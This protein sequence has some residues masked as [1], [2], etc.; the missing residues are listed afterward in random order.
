MLNRR[1]LLLGS[2]AATGTGLRSAAAQGSAETVRTAFIG[3]GNR[4]TYLLKGTIAHPGVKVMA[5]CDIK[6]D[7]L[8]RAATI[9]ANDK[10]TTYTDWRRLIERKDVDAVYIATPCDLHVEMAL[11]ALQAGKHIYCEKPIGV[12][13]ESVNRLWRAGK[14]AKTVFQ[15]GLG[16]RSSP[17]NRL[18]I[19]KIHDGIAGKLVMIRAWR[20]AGNDL[21]HNGSSND[22]F[23]N[24]KRSGD[25][26]VEMAVHNVDVCNWVAN[27]RP[28]SAGGY[29]GALVW[30]NE[31]PGRTNMDGYT[32][33]YDYANGVKL[34]FTQVFFHP[35]QM[36][37]GGSACLAY[38][39]KGGVDLNSATYYPREPKGPPVKL[40]EEDAGRRR[41]QG[42]PDGH[43][44]NFLNAI[45]TG[46]K[47]NAD[48]R[49]G[50]TATLTCILGREAIYKKRTMTW[51]DLGVDL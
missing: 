49:V 25:V 46:E 24:A 27:S 28:E 42:E 16:S 18:V 20:T 30:P 34:S 31:P 33:A 6:P 32:L 45:R 35:N 23:F 37:G 1:N 43:I 50:C 13:A 36:P 5:V 39:T 40:T 38:G 22:W 17:R 48:L 2:L 14:D 7:R 47:T 10:P 29:G 26:L 3:T 41:G 19:P 8:D 11:A 9:A 44:G 21:D 4:G 51:G 15:T 12:T